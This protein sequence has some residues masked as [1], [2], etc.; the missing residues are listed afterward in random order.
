MSRDTSLHIVALL[1]LHIECQDTV[2]CHPITPEKRV[3]MAIMNLA[4]PT[5]LCF[6]RNQFGMAP[7]M[8]GL[9]VY[10]V[11]Q[12]LP[13]IVVNSF[14][15]LQ[16]PREVVEGFKAMTFPNCVKKLSILNIDHCNILC[17]EK[18]EVITIS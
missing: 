6:V 4:T 5:S 11:C 18:E 16:N 7:C 15:C 3:A 12:L 8:A 2:M 14:I 1:S 10:E 13:D 9:A 17:E